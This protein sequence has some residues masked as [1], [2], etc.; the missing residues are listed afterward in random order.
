M[1]KVCHVNNPKTYGLFWVQRNNW[2]MFFRRPIWRFST[3]LNADKNK[4]LDNITQTVLFCSSYT[5]DIF[6][7]IYGIF[8]ST[9]KIELKEYQREALRRTPDYLTFSRTHADNKPHYY[10]ENICCT[11]YIIVVF[12]LPY[13]VD[14][15]L[16]MECAW[17]ILCSNYTR[18]LAFLRWVFKTYFP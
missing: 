13:L 2:Q 4:T 5:I 18:Y 17:Y 6:R 10:M 16:G 7:Y 9:V 11:I 14:C 3:I 8:R 12:W 1:L 15:G